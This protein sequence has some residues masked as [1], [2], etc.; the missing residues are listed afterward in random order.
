MTDLYSLSQSVFY[1]QHHNIIWCNPSTKLS[2]MEH[3]PSFN[4]YLKNMGGRLIGIY[5]VKC[6]FD[7][8]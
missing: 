7:E 5:T 1:T 2:R 4:I 3:F 8:K 6:V